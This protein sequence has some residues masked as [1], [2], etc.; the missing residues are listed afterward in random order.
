M[1]AG[2][3]AWPGCTQAQAHAPDVQLSGPGCVQSSGVDA[4]GHGASVAVASACRGWQGMS[5][6]ASPWA[7]VVAAWTTTTFMRVEA[8]TGAI[9][10]MT[11]A[12][13][14]S[15]RDRA[16]QGDMPVL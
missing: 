16:D 5:D 14:S 8:A 11:K 1:M 12:R 2:N 10:F 13:L 4:P 9:A 6:A 3:A 7:A 15:T